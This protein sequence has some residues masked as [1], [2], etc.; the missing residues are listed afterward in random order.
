LSIAVVVTFDAIVSISDKVNKL[1][2]TV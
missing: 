2:I 1:E